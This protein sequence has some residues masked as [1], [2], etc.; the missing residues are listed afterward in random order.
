MD[1]SLAIEANREALKRIVAMLVDMA[2][3]AEDSEAPTSPLW[4][5]RRASDR[6]VGLTAR[7]TP[8]P[9]GFADHLSPD[10]RG[11]GVGGCDDGRPSSPPLRGRG[12]ERSEAVRGLGGAL[13]MRMSCPP[14]PSSTSRP[15]P[16]ASRRPDHKGE[17]E[18][19]PK[20]PRLLWRAILAILR[21]AE[22]A[23]R[24]L[25][26]AASRGIVVEPPHPRPRKPQ[27][28]PIEPIY[29]KLGLAVMYNPGN[30]SRAA[31]I[32]PRS[33]GRGTMRSMVE[34]AHLSAAF[35]PAHLCARP[36]RAASPPAAA[37]GRGPD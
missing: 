21:P 16:D 12:A 22:S 20:L 23:A 8:S 31:P 6:R 10:R 7:S 3:F 32:L 5:G 18:G 4:G 36:Q 28:Q 27:P 15:P 2:G 24:R 13:A 35:G 11:R 37:I 33:R 14:C 30:A 29:R 19:P 25:I 1:G 17:G 34:G 9:I 26:I